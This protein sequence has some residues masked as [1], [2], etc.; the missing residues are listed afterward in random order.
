L[1]HPVTVVIQACADL[2]PIIDKSITTMAD[3]VA[4]EEKAT[5]AVNT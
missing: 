5:E 2:S 1:E 3:A 4:C